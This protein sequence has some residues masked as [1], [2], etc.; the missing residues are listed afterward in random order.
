LGLA[1]SK[2]LANH[3]GAELD[4]TES[5]IAGTTFVLRL[6]TSRCQPKLPMEVLVIG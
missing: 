2:Q 1:I 4:L 3:L 5:S 6:P